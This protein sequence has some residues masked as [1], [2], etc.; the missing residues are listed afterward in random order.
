MFFGVDVVLVEVKED[1]G[2]G[3]AGGVVSEKLEREGR[4]E[5]GTL[6]F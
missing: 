6:G 4:E 3:C 2:S 5:G 1:L